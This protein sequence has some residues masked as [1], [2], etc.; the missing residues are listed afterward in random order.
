MSPNHP[1]H[2]ASRRR[3]DRLRATPRLPVTSW[4]WLCLGLGLWPGCFSRPKPEIKYYE[5]A[6]PAPA[7][8]GTE[9]EGQGPSLVVRRL[10]AREPYAQ[11]RMVYRTSPYAIAFYNYQLWAS[12]PAEQVTHQT[13]KTLRGSG[14][15]SRVSSLPASS[16]DFLL[17]GVVRQ[18]EEIDGKDAWDAALEVDYWVSRPGEPS[19]F[20]F[21]TYRAVRRSGRRNPEAVAAAM[22]DNLA[23]VLGHLLA[24]LGP[25]VRQQAAV[26]KTTAGK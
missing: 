12:P 2:W 1:T 5:L 17:G 11:E 21:H 26:T 22:S 19:P 3:P 7:V 15:F 8:V 6:L 25:V 14:L 23:E 10:Q 4:P 24:D 13:A 9:A 20:W 18:F 16:G